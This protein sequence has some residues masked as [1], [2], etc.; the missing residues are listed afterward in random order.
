MF[1]AFTVEYVETAQPGTAA[2]LEEVLRPWA[3]LPRSD[4]QRAITV[5]YI[6]YHLQMQPFSELNASY[7]RPRTLCRATNAEQRQRAHSFRQCRSSLCSSGRTPASTVS[8]QILSNVPAR[9]LLRVVLGGVRCAQ[10]AVQRVPTRAEALRAIWHRPTKISTRTHD[11][12]RSTLG[13]DGKLRIRDGAGI[14][15]QSTMTCARLP[16]TTLLRFDWV[17]SYAAKTPTRTRKTSDMP[18]TTL[19][20]LHPSP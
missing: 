2:I 6:G 7:R 10:R 11:A 14:G 20:T 5:L 17:C 12:A 4:A 18:F 19:I 8:R 13:V 16:A 3:H 1:A 15:R 9:Q